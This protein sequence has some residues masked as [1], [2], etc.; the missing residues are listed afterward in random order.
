MDVVMLLLYVGIALI[1]GGPMTVG[2]FILVF[3]IFNFHVIGR[4]EVYL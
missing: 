3:V 2:P 1:A 4:E